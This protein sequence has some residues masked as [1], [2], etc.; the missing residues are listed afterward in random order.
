MCKWQ[1]FPNAEK[2]FDKSGGKCYNISAACS[3]QLSR[4]CT[5]RLGNG[6]FNAK[7]GALFMYAVMETGGKQYR[8]QVGDVI[9]VEKLDCEADSKVTLDKIVMVSGD[10]GVKVGAPYVDGA[11]VEATVLKN[12]KSKK[13]TVFT[14]KSKKN[15][16]RKMGHRQPYT[17]VR[18]DTING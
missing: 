11:S 14:Y 13:I 4:G 15:E 10:D 5:P 9:F 12:G 1:N 7:A 8:V 17:Q 6:E 2:T 3:G 18:I 16:K